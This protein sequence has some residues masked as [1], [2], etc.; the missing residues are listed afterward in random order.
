M[1]GVSPCILVLKADE[2][3][4]FCTDF[5]KVK[6]RFIPPPSDRGLHWA[7]LATLSILANSIY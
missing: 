6:A 4:R 5:R 2:T 1:P 3:F 7:L